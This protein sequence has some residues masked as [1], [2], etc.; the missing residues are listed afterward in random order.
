MFHRE[1]LRDSSIGR[2]QRN[3]VITN[4]SRRLSAEELMLKTLKSPWDCKIKP[5]HVKGSEVS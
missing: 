3:S 1:V 4:H 5:V 2:R